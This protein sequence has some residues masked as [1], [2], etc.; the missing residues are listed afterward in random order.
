TIKANPTAAM[1]LG[2]WPAASVRKT[3]KLAVYF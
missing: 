2:R 1:A 3:F